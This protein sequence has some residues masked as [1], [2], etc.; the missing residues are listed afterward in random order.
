MSMDDGQWADKVELRRCLEL[1][2]CG[3]DPGEGSAGRWLRRRLRAWR[4]DSDGASE[5]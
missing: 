3:E 4:A 5:R 1:L 2:S